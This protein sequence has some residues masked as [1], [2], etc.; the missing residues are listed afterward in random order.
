[1]AVTEDV[2][3]AVTAACAGDR[4]HNGPVAW[5]PA[6]GVHLCCNCRSHRTDAELR[7]TLAEGKKPS[8]GPYLFPL[9]R[10]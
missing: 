5:A 6:W 9:F 1:M 7:M 2:L 3:A 4:E 8:S 10:L